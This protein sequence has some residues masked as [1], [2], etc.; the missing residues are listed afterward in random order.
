MRHDVL[1]IAV[2]QSISA[3]AATK[4]ENHWEGVVQITGGGSW[5]SQLQTSLD[6]STWFNLGAA[7]T[8]ASPQLIAVT[9]GVKFLRMNTTAYASGTPVANYGGFDSRSE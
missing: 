1:A 4:I 8:N 3:G 7:A 6:G 9:N 2:P 5:T